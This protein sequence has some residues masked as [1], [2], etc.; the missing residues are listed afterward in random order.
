MDPAF[1][2]ELKRNTER[3]VRETGT[4]GVRLRGGPMDGWL[5]SE[6]APSLES[7]WFTTWPESVASKNEPGC[8]Q[9]VTP[10]DVESGEAIWQEFD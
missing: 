3:A 8:Y 4:P 2:E 6:D 9:V 10:M 7:D 1:W 5:V